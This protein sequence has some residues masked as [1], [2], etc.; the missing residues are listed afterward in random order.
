MAEYSSEFSPSST[1]ETIKA[2]HRR[3]K[4]AKPCGMFLIEG[5]TTVDA[6]AYDVVGDKIQLLEFPDNCRLIA[7][8]V[9]AD[10]EFDT[11]GTAVRF[12]L[13]VDQ[14]TESTTTTAAGSAFTN[15]PANDG[16]EVVSD[17][18]GDITQT[19]T[20]VGTT[21]GTDTVVVETITLNGVAQ[22]STVKVDWGFILAA[23]VASGTLTAASTVTIRE[24]SANQTVTTLTPTVTSRGVNS[25]AATQQAHGDQLV[26]LVC[27]GTSTKV[28]GLKGTDSDGTVIYDA[29]AL[30]NTTPVLSNSR[31]QTVTEVYS[32][33]LENTRTAT[34]T[35]TNPLLVTGSQFATGLPIPLNFTGGSTPGT[36]MGIDVSEDALALRVEVAPTTANTGDVT[37]TTKALV[38]CGDVADIGISN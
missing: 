11:G 9:I 18:A 20:I 2:A 27:S 38:W 1:Y 26:Q 30:T 13:V 35:A 3:Q 14:G 19:I 6:E 36:E 7:A 4:S 8:S 29:Q 15:Q 32:G 28:I 12:G 24:A 22:V 16:L 23:W 34:I 17:A 5:D 37:F 33:D 25:V 10:K 21:Q 31:F